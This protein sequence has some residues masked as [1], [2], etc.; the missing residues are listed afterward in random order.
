MAHSILGRTFKVNAAKHA[1][2]YDPRKAKKD[3]A[4]SDLVRGVVVKDEKGRFWLCG[5]VSDRST[6]VPGE[7]LENE[8]FHFTGNESLREISLA[9]LPVLRDVSFS[10]EMPRDPAKMPTFAGEFLIDHKTLMGTTGAPIGP[11]TAGH[12]HLMPGLIRMNQRLDRILERERRIERAVEDVLT[13]DALKDT[14]SYTDFPIK[15]GFTPH[16]NAPTRRAFD[17]RVLDLALKAAIS[18]RDAG[19]CSPC[20]ND[21]P[22]EIRGMK[23]WN[24]FLAGEIDGAASDHSRHQQYLA[25]ELEAAP[26]FRYFIYA[27]HSVGTDVLKDVWEE[28][29]PGKTYNYKDYPQISKDRYDMALSQIREGMITDISREDTIHLISADFH[30]RLDSKV[31]IKLVGSP[32]TPV[33]GAREGNTIIPLPVLDDPK[34][35]RHLPL[36]VPSGRLVVAEWPQVKGFTEAVNKICQG[37]NYEVD[38]IDETDLQARHY[39]ERMGIVTIQVSNGPD[40]FLD[41]PGVLRFGRIDE[42]HEDLWKKK[43]GDFKYVGPK[44]AV[45]IDGRVWCRV[46][47]DVETVVDA[48]MASGLYDDRQEAMTALEDH[49]EKSDEIAIVEIG[50]TEAH[51]YMPTG[52][53]AKKHNFRE[54]FRAAEIAY[55]DWRKDEFVL[56]V[57]PLTVDPEIL[58]DHDWVEGRIDPEITLR[59]ED[60]S[61]EP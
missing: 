5:D 6:S 23:S 58:E 27:L 14:F 42:D 52:Y 54:V 28:G 55:P 44:A 45:K 31:H 30:S 25:D 60:D 38:K 18:L 7:V 22:H 4:R 17:K 13:K 20:P 61:P 26:F 11:V 37:D 57:H 9:V 48:L 24:A 36:S 53:G 49:N 50:A 34:P 29:N 56:S 1:A 51:L 21:G 3:A 39:Y 40:G 33:L 32:L 12:D 43:N 10:E 2:A 47:A 8:K 15:E 59:R 35:V 19:L 41:E 46:M 16:Y